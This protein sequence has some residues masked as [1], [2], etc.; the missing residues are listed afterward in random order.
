VSLFCLGSVLFC[1]PG[2]EDFVAALAFVC[3][4]KKLKGGKDLEGLGEGKT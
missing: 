2:L 4:E 3:L 1:F